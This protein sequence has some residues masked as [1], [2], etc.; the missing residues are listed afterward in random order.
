MKEAGRGDETPFRH[1]RAPGTHQGLQCVL[2]G[3]AVVVVMPALG[4]EN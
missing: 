2:V 3:Q 4:E 1:I